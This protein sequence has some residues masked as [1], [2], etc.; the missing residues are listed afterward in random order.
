MTTTL[1]L[2]KA[3]F[4]LDGLFFSQIEKPT[5]SLRP[6]RHNELTLPKIGRLHVDT[7]L[8]HHPNSDNVMRPMVVA[9]LLCFSTGELAW[10]KVQA[11]RRP[12]G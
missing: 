11:A 6:Q 10:Y 2:L 3:R 9:R 5:T 1:P 8:T 7:Y 4:E 12:H